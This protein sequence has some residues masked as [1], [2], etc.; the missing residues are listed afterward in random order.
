MLGVKGGG[1]GRILAA[2]RGGIY[3]ARRLAISRIRNIAPAQGRRQGCDEHDGTGNQWT[4]IQAGVARSD[5]QAD[6]EER[7]ADRQKYRSGRRHGAPSVSGRSRRLGHRCCLG[8]RSVLSV[9]RASP[10]QQDESDHG[11]GQCCPDDRVISHRCGLAS[12]S[13]LRMRPICLVP[14]AAPLSELVDLARLGIDDRLRQPQNLLS[15]RLRQRALRSID[16]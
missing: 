6:A 16:S 4:G 13:K 11:A 14:L 1:H 9:T 2:G 5:R 8:P 15:V 10:A 12:R 3:V 7:K